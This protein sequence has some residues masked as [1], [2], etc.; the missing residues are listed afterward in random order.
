MYF[1]K[2]DL[3]AKGGFGGKGCRDP[4]LMSSDWCLG[5]VRGEGPVWDDLPSQ[6]LGMKNI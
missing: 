2:R 5:K 1:V 6:G 4:S 3:E